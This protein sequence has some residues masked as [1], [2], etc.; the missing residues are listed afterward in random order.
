MALRHWN[1]R[2]VQNA[3]S[4]LNRPPRQMLVDWAHVLPETG[5]VLDAG[6]AVH[7]LQVGLEVV[8]RVAGANLDHGQRVTA[9]VPGE[10]GQRALAR[11]PAA[12]EPGVAAR[13]AHDARDAADVAHSIV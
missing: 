6:A 3:E 5:V 1:E 10:L 2:Y 4:W 12:D 8:Q 11:P 9:H 13:V 7:C